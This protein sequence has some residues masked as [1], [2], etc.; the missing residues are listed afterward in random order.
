MSLFVELRDLGRFALDRVLDACD[1]RDRRVV[2]LLL[3]AGMAGC[4]NDGQVPVYPVSGRVGV[5]GES[6]AGALLVFHPQS[7]PQKPGV[8]IPKPVGRVQSD[9]TFKLT[10]YSENDGAP[11]GD[12]SVTVEW[13]PLVKQDGD[14][15]AGP[16]VIGDE[17]GKPESTPLHVN[18]G[19]SSKS[20]DPIELKRS[21]AVKAGPGT[22]T[23]AG[24]IRGED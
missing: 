20:L 11:A 3:A 19:T 23:T 8:E 5:E 4:S 10:T 6:P 17:Y 1:L 12:Y 7:A 14:M 22:R 13:R 16:N 9:G 2:L 21:K 24:R 18:V 15:K